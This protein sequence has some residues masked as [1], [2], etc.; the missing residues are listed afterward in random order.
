MKKGL[1]FILG[2][3]V[4]SLTVYCYA[5]KYRC[6]KASGTKVCVEAGHSVPYGA[7]VTT[8]RLL[9]IDD[10]DFTQ[11]SAEPYPRLAWD[12]EEINYTAA[13]QN[14]T[15]TVIDCTAIWVKNRGAQQIVYLQSLS[16][17]YPM[18]MD[19]GTTIEVKVG[20]R[21]NVLYFTPVGSGT[22][23]NVTVWSFK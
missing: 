22:D 2:L 23:G 21:F 9:G 7:N 14:S 16:N 12:Y 17:P 8:D 19:T 10:G 15:L 6:D 4:I 13:S 3:I 20:H 1:S 11:L 5:G 18:L